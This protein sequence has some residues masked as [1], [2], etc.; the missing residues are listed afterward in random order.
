MTYHDHC[1][2]SQVARGAIGWPMNMFVGLVNQKLMAGP[3]QYFCSTLHTTLGYMAYCMW[4]S[5]M[6]VIYCFYWFTANKITSTVDLVWRFATIHRWKVWPQIKCASPYKESATPIKTCLLFCFVFFVVILLIFVAIVISCMFSS[7]TLLL[8][9]RYC[10]E[11][12][13][14]KYTQVTRTDHNI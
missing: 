11:F 1:G 5:V 13:M 3:P 9:T 2:N 8:Y 6:I 12:L 7:G 10:Y 4:L 14:Q